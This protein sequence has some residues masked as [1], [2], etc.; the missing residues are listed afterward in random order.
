[1]RLAMWLLLLLFL[2]CC[3]G[4]GCSGSQE[5]SSRQTT[6]PPPKSDLSRLPQ[7]EPQRP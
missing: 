1:M 2:D 6:Q 3:L 4:L 7:R 5:A